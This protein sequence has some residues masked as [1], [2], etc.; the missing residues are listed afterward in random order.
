MASDASPASKGRSAE[1]TKQAMLAAACRRFVLESYENVGMRD[2]AGDVGVDVALV[3]RYFGNK[4]ELF[5]EVLGVGRQK[6]ILPAEL[7]DDQIPAYLA[8][9]YLAQD[10]DRDQNVDRLLIILRSASSPVASQIVRDA[11]RRDVLTPLA[12][13]LRGDKPELRASTSLA[14]WMGMTIMRTVIGVDPLKGCGAEIESRLQRL[15]E[16]A[17]SDETKA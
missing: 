9:L 6:D 15:F 10:S 16:S 5:K 2:I 1:A 4:E 13:R 11:L 17:L 8:S 14:V 3:S 7:A 12:E